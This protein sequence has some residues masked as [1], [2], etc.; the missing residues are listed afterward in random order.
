[1]TIVFTQATVEDAPCPS[2]KV[3]TGGSST[4]IIATVQQAPDWFSF[5]PNYNGA[6][7]AGTRMLEQPGKHGTL[8]AGSAARAAQANQTSL[9]GR[10]RP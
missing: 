8:Q 4:G 5:V 3:S 9:I 10:R 2:S 1:M 6:T 7:S